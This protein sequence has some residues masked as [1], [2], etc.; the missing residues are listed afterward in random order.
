RN[1]PKH[2][3]AVSIKG[4][5]KKAADHKAQWTADPDRGWVT[6]EESHG[7]RGGEQSWTAPKQM[8]GKSKGARK[9]R[10]PF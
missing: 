2:R 3:D 9:A 5:S 10:K 1:F 7:I 8:N 6:S 4:N